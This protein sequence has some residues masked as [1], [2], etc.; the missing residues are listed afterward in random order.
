MKFQQRKKLKE[1][2]YR[3]YMIPKV[4]TTEYSQKNPYHPGFGAVISKGHAVIVKRRG[5]YIPENIA[6]KFFTQ[7]RELFFEMFPKFDP[8]Y[9]KIMNIKA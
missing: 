8:E 6:G 7:V 4:S 9:K 1:N 5:E 3:D 2:H